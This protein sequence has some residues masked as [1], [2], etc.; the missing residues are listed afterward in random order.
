[1]TKEI[2]EKSNKNL[3]KVKKEKKKRKSIGQYF[4]EVTAE[5]KKVTWPTRKDLTSYTITVIVFV[6]IFAALVGAI[7]W[8]LATG[9]GL[10]IK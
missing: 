3:S 8:L 4:K 1:M 7:D 2:A 10:V 6:V 9:L 5:L